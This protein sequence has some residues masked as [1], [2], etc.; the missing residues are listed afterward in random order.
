MKVKYGVCLCIEVEWEGKRLK[1][2]VAILL[3]TRPCSVSSKRG[4]FVL[5]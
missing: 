2:T 5:T 1:T 4:L 3:K